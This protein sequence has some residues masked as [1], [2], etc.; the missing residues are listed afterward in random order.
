M[1]V[2][3]SIMSNARIGSSSWRISKKAGKCF[4][5]S[6]SNVKGVQTTL[7]KLFLVV[8]L[9]F[10]FVDVFELGFYLISFWFEKWPTLLQ[11]FELRIFCDSIPYIP[12]MRNKKLVWYLKFE[13]R[14]LQQLLE[15]RTI[16][17]LQPRCLI[18]LLCRFFKWKIWK[19]SQGK[20]IYWA[21]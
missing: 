8:L 17:H 12:V 11:S 16:L 3:K 9:N 14:S 20:Y 10:T 7:Q 18:T 15:L 2:P 13:I 4:E 6:H 19:T 21:A 1:N 5:M